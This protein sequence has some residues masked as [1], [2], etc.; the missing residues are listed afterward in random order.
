MICPGI[1]GQSLWVDK[2]LHMYRY[3]YILLYMLYIH[4]MV[5]ESVKELGLCQRN[6]PLLTCEGNIVDFK[7]F[8]ERLI[9]VRTSSV[10][11]P[12]NQSGVVIW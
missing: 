8:S 6:T 9:L 2:T 1:P 3:G 7:Y 12:T 10:H 11:E 5:L 4:H